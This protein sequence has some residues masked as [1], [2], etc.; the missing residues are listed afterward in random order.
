M[1]CMR[2]KEYRLML[3]KADGVVYLHKKGQMFKAVDALME[4]NHA[5]CDVSDKTLRRKNMP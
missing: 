5:M 4:R 2:G 1:Y 3:E